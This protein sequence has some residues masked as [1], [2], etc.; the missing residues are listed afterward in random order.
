[1]LWLNRISKPEGVNRELLSLFK[2]KLLQHL[3][4]AQATSRAWG[5]KVAAIQGI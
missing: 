2:V 1:M 4:Y 5:V 3:G